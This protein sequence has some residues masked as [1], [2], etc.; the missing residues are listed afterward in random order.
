MLKLIQLF[1]DEAF[2]KRIRH[3]ISKISVDADIKQTSAELYF[4]GS[5]TMRRDIIYIVNSDVFDDFSKSL[6]QI[7][8]SNI[9]LFAYIEDDN[10]S[11]DHVKN[12]VDFYLSK[13]FKNIDLHAVLNQSKKLLFGHAKTSFPR[14]L[15]HASVS[16][17]EQLLDSISQ[18]IFWKDCNG[19]YIGCNKSFA[20]D[21]GLNSSNEIIGKT[22]SDLFDEKAVLDFSA[23]DHQIIRT[24]E[25]F[26]DF[27]KEIDLKTGTKMWICMSKFPHVKE[28]EIVGII[29]RYEIIAEDDPTVND[30]FSNEMLLNTLMENIP[31]II[32]FKDKENRFIRINEAA[33]NLFGV[34]SELEA[35]GKT[36]F[37]FFEEKQAKEAF[38]IEQEILFTGEP[39]RNVEKI[40]K[41]NERY[42]C[43]DSLK[44]PIKNK[45]GLII[46]TA[47]ITRD[48][49]GKDEKEKAIRENMLKNNF[50]SNMSH[51]IRTPMNGI[52]GMSEVLSM[53]NLTPEQHKMVQ[54]IKRSGDSML[55]II[56]NILDMYKIDSGK[57]F[58]QKRKINIERIVSEI[59]ESHTVEAKENS[60]ILL[61]RIDLNLP[62]TI[63]GDGYK[64][65]QILVNLV[66]NAIKFTQNG[67]VRIEVKSIGSSDNQHYI[68]FKVIDTGIGMDVNDIEQIFESFTQ[69]DEST[70]KKYGG[71]GLGLSISNKLIEMMGGKLKVNIVKDK[72]SIFFFE[73]MFDKAEIDELVK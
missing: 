4:S 60:N 53:D 8:I 29:G 56:D 2:Y 7:S 47:G 25:C 44:I 66:N 49:S 1:E 28:G 43:F 6:K 9:I 73:L 45:H 34:N 14:K 40:N 23:F 71:T 59:I 32:Y 17:I 35:I 42:M 67:E 27:K 30:D 18:R 64:L 3:S 36:D 72:G 46:G 54:I 50:M 70:T 21:L 24:G 13:S 51:E 26:E 19:K 20:S 37:D 22:D 5:D 62:E 38:A 68:K 11:N 33:R 58:I 12:L 55:T 65:K 69:A 10:I 63:I 15:I 31:D 41:K 57:I 52:I 16:E 39:R 61:Q 48:I